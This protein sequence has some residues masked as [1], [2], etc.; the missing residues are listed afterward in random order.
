MSFV[1]VAF[2]KFVALSD[3]QTLRQW[4][5]DRCTQL[6]I[7]G[8]IL[9][10]TEGINGTI[11]G[12]RS[13]IDAILSELRH[14][15]Q[16]T[17]LDWKESFAES[18]PFDRLKVKIK[19]EIVTLGFPEIDP[20]TQVGTYVS[21]EDWNA[22]ISDPDVTVIDTRNEF[23]V[24]IGSFEGAENP[25]T[26]SFRDFPKFVQQTLNPATHRKVALFCTG[27]IR[28]EKAS[29]YL[30]SQGFPEVYHL[31]G[32]IL[33]YLETVPA[34]E[35]L[36]N[37]QCFVFDQRISVEHRLTPVPYQL[38][39]KCGQPILCAPISSSTSVPSEASSLNRK[40][41]PVC[42]HCNRDDGENISVAIA[43]L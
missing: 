10:A 23:E 7:K 29:A 16:F 26:R 14:Q 19:L 6:D 37:G 18:P 25:R 42:P 28:C 13:N 38:C 9:L 40:L 35:S 22:L 4:L 27:G 8:T 41:Q 15:P 5:V 21:P 30:L 24:A 2:Y 36:W 17:D 1:V 39:S 33:K 11:A 31:K 3:C 12:S 20:A 32:G 43:P 34:E